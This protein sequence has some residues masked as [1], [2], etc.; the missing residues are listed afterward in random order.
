MKF[1][2][3]GAAG[4][5][6]GSSFLLEAGK[7]K[8]L[9]DCGLFQGGPE[10][11]QRNQEFP[12][13]PREIKAVFLTHAHLDHC[14]RLPLLYKK[15]FRGRIYST[16]A[17]RDL[18]QFILLDAS[19]VQEE[20]FLK[21]SRKKRRAG[22]EALPPLY[23]DGDVLFTTSH[24]QPVPYDSPIRVENGFQITFRQSGHVL[25]SAFLVFEEKGKR[26]IFSGDLGSPHRN[27][28]P[29][30]DF[31]PPC[32]LVVCEST[33][34]DRSHKTIQESISELKEAINWAYK[35]G[36]NVV[37]PSFALERAQDVLYYLKNLRMKGEVPSNP[38]FLDSPLSINLT[39]VY[40]HHT[41]ELDEE[42]RDLIM[43]GDEP[44]SFPGLRFTPSVEQSRAIN[45]KNQI[46]VIAGSGMCQGG[47][48][49][50]HLKHNL[51][52]E[53]SAV[54]F[55]G[56]QARQ[57]LGRAIVEG[58]K[59]VHIYGEPIAVKARIYTINGFSAHGDQKVLLEWLEKTNGALILLNHGEE[60]SASAFA[61][62]LKGIGRKVELAEPQKI[63]EV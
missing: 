16:S 15:G 50:H 14:G 1:T 33:Y 13:D 18:A 42:I 41:D 19:K 5:V 22:E 57:T 35:A 52:R 10:A 58:A 34:G 59:K 45:E 30:P 31:P 25:G 21:Q 51:W 27:V 28:V 44:F 56:Y 55:V 46:I 20:D 39:E 61:S 62:I 7:N 17:T 40:R 63:Y 32:D 8:Y 54:V 53:D 48:V 23:S 12:F 36:G 37:I 38:V 9:V 4:E 6:T 29:D 49:L 60:H 3:I 26:L 43:K 11:E 47:R 2:P 24:F